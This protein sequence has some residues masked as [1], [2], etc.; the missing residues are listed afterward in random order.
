MKL[1][2]R[3]LIFLLFVIANYLCVK[4]VDN[5]IL[6]FL[7]LAT[8]FTAG[9]F[10]VFKPIKL[11][12]NMLNSVSEEDY[13][14]SKKLGGLGKTGNNFNLLLNRLMISR[15]SLNILFTASKTITSRVEIEDVMNMILDLE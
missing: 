2:F 5:N 15:E 1:S 9:Y 7:T 14:Q 13:H 4:N 12:E 10:F 11:M 3:V 8:V 6:T